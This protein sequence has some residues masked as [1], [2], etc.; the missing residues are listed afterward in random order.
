MVTWIE[1]AKN[2]AMAA[3]FFA[4]SNIAQII[5]MRHYCFHYLRIN[6]SLQRRVEVRKEARWH[7]PSIIYKSFSASWDRYTSLPYSICSGP[8]W[9][10]LILYHDQKRHKATETSET[11]PDSP[12][13][14]S[15]N[16][17]CDVCHFAANWDWNDWDF[18]VMSVVWFHSINSKCHYGPF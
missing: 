10:S 5:K 15:L 1:S 3:E 8:P 13:F 9:G 7:A 14:S 12:N 18:L 4:I 11:C 17:F 16:R 2:F 6:L